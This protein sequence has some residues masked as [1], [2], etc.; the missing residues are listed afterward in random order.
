MKFLTTHGSCWMDRDSIKQDRKQRGMK[1][2][3]REKRRSLFF[4][5]VESEVVVEAGNWQPRSV[6]QD[7]SLIEGKNK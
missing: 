2:K 1:W 6:F 7:G 3:F 5:P 4:A